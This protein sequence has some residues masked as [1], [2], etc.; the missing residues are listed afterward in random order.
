VLFNAHIWQYI[1]L[2]L[3]LKLKKHNTLADVQLWTFDKFA[4]TLKSFVGKD[5]SRK[6]NG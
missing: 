6:G 3:S 4:G 2:S 5:T 1:T